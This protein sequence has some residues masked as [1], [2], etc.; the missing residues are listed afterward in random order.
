VGTRDAKDPQRRFRAPDFRFRK[1]NNHVELVE[2]TIITAE[3]IGPLAFPPVP[4]SIKSLP[5]KSPATRAAASQAHAPESGSR[6]PL[7][8]TTHIYPFVDPRHFHEEP[9]ASESSMELVYSVDWRMQTNLADWG[10]VPSTCHC[11]QLGEDRQTF[12]RAPHFLAE[13]KL[14]E[15][16]VDGSWTERKTAIP[17]AT[18]IASSLQNWVIDR[19]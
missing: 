10:D 3:A 8:V 4:V 1:I 11:Q 15:E 7:K 14:F 13:A 9:A 2:L 19:S 5:S 16:I 18:G 6:T 12:Q 17:S